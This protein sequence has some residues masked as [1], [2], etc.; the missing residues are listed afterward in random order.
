[1][2]LGGA[3]AGVLRAISV[4][5]VISLGAGDVVVAALVTLTPASSGRARRGWACL[6]GVLEGLY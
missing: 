5:L 6:F 2:A 3:G 1:M 4:A